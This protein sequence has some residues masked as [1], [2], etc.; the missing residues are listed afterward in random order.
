MQRITD[1]HIQIAGKKVGTLALYHGVAAFE[2]SSDWLAQ[3]FSL[4]PFSLPLQTGVFMPKYHPFDGVFGIFSDSLPDGWGRLLLDRLLRSLGENPEVLGPLD[5]LCI[6]GSTGMG[7]LEYIPECRLGGRTECADFDQLASECAKVLIEQEPDDLDRLFRMGGSS[8]GARPK[9]FATID[10]QPWIV[11]FRSSI[12]EK[13]A[14]KME[15][16]Y[17]CCARE[18]GIEVPQ[19]ALLPSDECAG[20]FAVQRFDRRRQSDG[21]QKRIHMASVSAL[22]ET[23]HR[24]PNLDYKQLMKLT[25]IITQNNIAELKKMFRLMCFNVFAHNRDDHSK[26]FSFLYDDV[27]SEWHLSPAYDLTYSSSLAG[28]HA[29]TV[30]G[31]GENPSIADIMRVVQSTDLDADWASDTAQCI[32]DVVTRQLEEYLRLK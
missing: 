12:D 11:K 31:N 16:D 28:Q 32:H 21:T 25:A 30:A 24:V 15:Y 27:K 22:L 13:N 8:G 26:N 20:Y 4:S 9:V 19:V 17:A 1:A 29:T 14:G 10:W 18:C 3:G 23:S 7:A 2:Y 6:V 5:R